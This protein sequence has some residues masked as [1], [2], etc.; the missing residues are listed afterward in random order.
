MDR[1]DKN[2]IQSKSGMGWDGQ[3][4]R[5]GLQVALNATIKM[6]Y[7]LHQYPKE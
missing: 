5:H 3:M 1:G 2:W 7:Q 4:I 6:S